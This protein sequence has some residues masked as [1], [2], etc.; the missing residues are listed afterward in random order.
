MNPLI[1]R[2]L[3]GFLVASLI[4]A[5]GASSSEAEPALLC[6][7]PQVGH[8]DPG[9]RD[10]YVLAPSNDAVVVVSV[11][12]L[13]DSP[14]LLRIKAE[15]GAETCSGS[16]TLAVSPGATVEIS[17]CIGDN[18]IDYT[19]TA[20]VVSGGPANCAE[21]LPCGLVPAVRELT[22]PGEVDAFR[23]PA[24]KREEVVVRAQDFLAR[25]AVSL[26][27]FDPEG[28]VVNGAGSCTGELRF[29][30][31]HN[32]QHTVIVGS[33][34][35]AHAGRYTL[36]FRGESCPAG[37]EISHI[38]LARS[39]GS[40]IDP[41]GYDA[42]GRP[43]YT[44][45]GGAG[46]TLVIEGTPGTDGEVPGLLAYAHQEGVP[47]V[48][49]DLQVLVSRAL[50]DGNPAVCPNNPDLRDG[51]A[52]SPSLD[53]SPTLQ[54]TNAI[55]D[56]GCRVNDG[57]GRALGVD[58]PVDACTV[59][60]DGSSRFVVPYSKVQFC[61]QVPAV[62]QFPLGD[63]IVAA[64]LRSVEGVVGPA[65]QMIVRIEAVPTPT[66]TATRP[67]E[68]TPTPTMPL[69]A[70][71]GDCDGDGE[72]SF[73]EIWDALVMDLQDQAEP[74]MDSDRSGR[75]SIDELVRMVRRLDEGCPVE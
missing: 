23:F 33:C 52:A 29:R 42:A 30:P 15:G 66:P 69:P 16:L 60:S 20:N 11:V 5:L 72:I 57:T 1:R 10:V 13:S 6:G 38:G 36:G 26:Q 54:V 18:A 74:C 49:P 39:D 75:V 19:I 51:I 44:R 41:I 37:P 64:R 46:F 31:R 4:L 67:G 55:N 58:M 9:S 68:A 3:G 59:F 56:F 73:F 70:C 34:L 53:F 8:L 65:R 35:E 12:D 27:V 40:P 21:P 43:I 61:S 45:V 50:G 63:T 28:A 32:G 62:R 71:A 22:V 47:E 48:L 17:D 25:G 2:G 24:F 14:S 7:I